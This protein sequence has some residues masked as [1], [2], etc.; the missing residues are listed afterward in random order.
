MTFSPIISP[1]IVPVA[2]ATPSTNSLMS[3]LV[4]WPNILYLKPLSISLVK[5]YCCYTFQILVNEV[6]LTLTCHFGRHR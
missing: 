1:I 2:S 4:A 5:I 6:L 3:S